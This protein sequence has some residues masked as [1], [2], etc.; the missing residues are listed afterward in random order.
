M[1]YV[2]P[3]NFIVPVIFVKNFT[4]KK[5]YE[6]INENFDEY[7]QSHDER[8]KIRERLKQEEWEKF[9]NDDKKEY[10]DKLQKELVMDWEYDEEYSQEIDYKYID[11]EYAYVETEKI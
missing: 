11:K 4:N 2:Y 7:N 9:R 1:L 5:I 8:E 10:Y 3:D 6:E